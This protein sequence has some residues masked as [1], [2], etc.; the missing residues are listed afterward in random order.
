MRPDNW[1]RQTGAALLTWA[2]LL[3]A[4]TE[5]IEIQ[6][7]SPV[8]VIAGKNATLSV[9]FTSSSPPHVAWALGATFASWDVGQNG[10]VKV[11]SEFLGRITVNTSSASM[12]ILQSTLSDSRNYAVTLSALN[13]QSASRN[14]SLRVYELISNVKVTAP[15]GVIKEGDTSVALSC[16]MVT[17]TWD[18]LT[19]AKNGMEVVS[20]THTVIA[21]NELKIQS[22]VREDAGEYSCHVKNPFSNGSARGLLN[23]YYGPDVPTV[24]IVSATDP[25]PAQFVLVNAT[26]NLT[27]ATSSAPPAQ[28]F[29]SV[30]ESGD[31]SVPSGPVLVLSR[32]QLEQAG[33]YS[34]IVVNAKLGDSKRTA[35]A[36]NVYELPPGSPECSMTSIASNKALQFS[37]SWPGGFPKA[38]IRWLGLLR[39]VSAESQLVQNQ[40]SPADL[41]GR[42][43]T[44]VAGHRAAVK[45]CI[46]KPAIPLVS[47]SR[48]V[49]G[50]TQGDVTVTLKCEVTS[51]PAPVIRWYKGQGPLASG[52]KI[53]ISPDSSEVRIRSFSLVNDTGNYSCSCINPLGGSSSTLTLTAPLVSDV[54]VTR[55]NGTTA[56][57]SWG[58]R[59]SDVV[60][61]FLVQRRTDTQRGSSSSGP[62]ADSWVTVQ[63]TG[64]DGRTATLSQL[65]EDLAYSFRVLPKT[66]T[67]SGEPSPSQSVAPTA[68]NRLSG[69]AIAGIIVG[70]V[71]GFLL[72]LLLIA[73]LVLWKFKKKKKVIVEKQTAN[74]QKDTSRQRSIPNGTGPSVFPRGGLPQPPPRRSIS[75]KTGLTAEYS[76]TE[77]SLC[78]KSPDVIGPY[79]FAKTQSLE[80][81]SQEKHSARAEL[82][83][84]NGQS[85]L[86]SRAITI[87]ERLATMV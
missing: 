53:V 47:P 32:V 24:E 48:Q 66:G 46:V 20:N 81:S 6:A 57:I 65:Q 5:S 21:G 31:T 64:M 78:P 62:R 26:V 9:E 16:T 18:A 37:C 71:I 80:S 8:R 19:W 85:P 50:E 84:H 25:D 52:E 75:N 41:S 83:Q 14:I 30:G 58:V 44:C 59:E 60:T 73:G 70:C 2:A 23:V 4:L 17:G 87:Q 68:D 11:S 15:E 79:P 74:K 22:V 43:V 28:Y 7:S 34:C 86:Q 76:D 51:N 38:E 45:T 36:L 33:R 77:S 72:I 12:V 55:I 29:W 3:V 61:S 13:E 1:S 67:Q 40:S 54:T 35:V 69:G 63:E 39:N 56:S 27:C 82:P 42:D 49:V 10:S